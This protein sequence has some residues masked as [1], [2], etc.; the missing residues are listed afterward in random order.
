MRRKAFGWK[1]QILSSEKNG[2]QMFYKR[3][4][5]YRRSSTTSETIV[6][7]IAVF[8]FTA[9]SIIRRKTAWRKFRMKP[10]A[11]EHTTW[12]GMCRK[13]PTSAK[14]KGLWTGTR[15]IL[16]RSA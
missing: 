15:M 4:Y 7:M 16:T 9:P 12:R 5:T 2:Y 14:A 11:T 8:P 6:L 13:L 3:G 1:L 10:N